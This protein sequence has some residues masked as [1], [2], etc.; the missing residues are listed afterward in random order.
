MKKLTTVVFNKNPKL[1][2]KIVTTLCKS[3]FEM[4]KEEIKKFGTIEKKLDYVA[5]DL[6]KGHNYEYSIS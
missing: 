1:T 3:F 5:N 4:T 2:N 6:A